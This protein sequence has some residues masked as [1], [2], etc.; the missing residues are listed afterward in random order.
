MARMMVVFEVH[1][2]PGC[3]PTHILTQETLRDTQAQVMTR[4]EAHKVGFH[5]LPEPP[6]DHEV[7]YVAVAKRDEQRIQRSFESNEVVGL[8]RKFDVD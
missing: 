8:F 5:G 6:A 7:R 4:A 1:V 2:V 3:D